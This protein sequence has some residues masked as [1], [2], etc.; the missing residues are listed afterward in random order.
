LGRYLFGA[1]FAAEQQYDANQMLMDI[2]NLQN[3]NPWDLN[4]KEPGKESTDCQHSSSYHVE[5]EPL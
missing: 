4:Y 3:I 1:F 2:S 5:N